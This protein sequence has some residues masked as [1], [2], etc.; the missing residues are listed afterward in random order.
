MLNLENNL[1]SDIP[2]DLLTNMTALT[3]LHLGS[4]QLIVV[5]DLSTVGNTL[6]TLDLHNN[7]IKDISA[8]VLTNMTALKH[9]DLRSNKITDISSEAFVGAS[10][11][12][13]LALYGNS[14]SLL[15]DLRNMVIKLQNLDVRFNPVNV[16]A[17]E[18]LWLKEAQQANVT[19][20]VDDLNSTCWTT[21]GHQKLQKDCG[22]LS[23]KLHGIHASQNYKIDGN[24]AYKSHCDF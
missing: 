2:P 9:L 8:Y 14:I 15:P 19:V 16:C 23:S 10:S 24:F 17:C 20:L 7:L 11:L 5:P 3:H 21:A 18:N 22:K 4:N 13:I 12:T 1:I 6:L